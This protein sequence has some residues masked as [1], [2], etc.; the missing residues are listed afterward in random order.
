MVTIEIKETFIKNAETQNNYFFFL[1]AVS[2]CRTVSVG[3]GRDELEA[4]EA[5]EVAID[6]R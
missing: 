4:G 5:D 3:M 6:S 2:C 1:F